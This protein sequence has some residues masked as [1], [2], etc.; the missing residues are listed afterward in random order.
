MWVVILPSDG[1]ATEMAFYSSSSYSERSLK[2]VRL[3]M[4]PKRGQGVFRVSGHPKHPH[5]FFVKNKE[6]TV[7]FIA[8]SK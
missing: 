8:S 3:S 5:M 7:R 1:S 4:Q 6:K 2:P